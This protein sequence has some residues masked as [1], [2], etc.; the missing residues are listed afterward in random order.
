MELLD[1]PAPLHELDGQPVEQLRMRRLL[2]HLAEVVERR[3]DAAAEVVVPHAVDDHARG[4][5]ILGRPDPLGERQPPSR[6]AAIGT[7][8]LGRVLAVQSPRVR[9]PGFISEPLLSGSPRI[10]KCVGGGSYVPGPSCRNVPFGLSGGG[11]RHFGQPIVSSPRP[12]G[13]KRQSPSVMIS[14][15]GSGV[16]PLL[17]E[18]RDLRGEL[19]LLRLLLRR[20]QL[21]DVVRGC[22]RRHR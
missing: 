4:E 21:F 16:G 13:A 10:R 18:R 14:A 12:I 20:H 15:I 6:R 2:A 8:N 19:F 7:R 3:D 1:A 9:K 11:S 5:R 22:R 17:L